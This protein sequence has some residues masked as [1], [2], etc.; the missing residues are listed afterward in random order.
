MMD[1]LQEVVTSH[2]S[3]TGEGAP[4]AGGVIDGLG[5]RQETMPMNL[6]QY[7]VRPR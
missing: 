4:A 7:A 2:G 6:M 3:S 5:G 1:A